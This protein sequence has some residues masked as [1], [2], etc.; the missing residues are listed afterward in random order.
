MDVKKRKP[1]TFSCPY[2]SSVSDIDGDV[3]LHLLFRIKDL[4]VCYLRNDLDWDMDESFVFSSESEIRKQIE[5]LETPLAICYRIEKNDS[6]YYLGFCQT[7]EA[8]VEDVLSNGK[9]G[10]S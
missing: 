2:C 5:N 1:E 9:F 10:K 7:K 8:L 3:C 4:N 6:T